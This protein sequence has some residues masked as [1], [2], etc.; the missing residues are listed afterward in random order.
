MRAT[1]EAGGRGSGSGGNGGVEEEEKETKQGGGG[2]GIACI[3][4]HCPHLHLALEGVNAANVEVELERST[5][6]GPWRRGAG[7][8]GCP[9]RRLGPGRGGGLVDVH[10]GA[11][12]VDTMRWISWRASCCGC[13]GEHQY[14][15]WYMMRRAPVHD[16]V[17]DA[18]STGTRR[19]G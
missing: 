5:V 19:G 4:A 9:L 14:T 3:H 8:V 10:R 13:P 16:A 15:V 7:S 11:G 17:D 12:S 2:G 18:A 6:G 1:G